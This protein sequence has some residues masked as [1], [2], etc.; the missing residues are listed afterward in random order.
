[1]GRLDY[2]PIVLAVG[3]NDPNLVVL[4]GDINHGI[5]QPFAAACPGRFYNVGILE[6]TIMSMAA[7]LARIGLLPVVHTI[8]P[9]LI[10]RSFEQIKHDFCYH[11]LHGNLITVG[12]A[13]D[14]AVLGCTHHY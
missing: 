9:F 12:S 7:G 6:P 5:L 13:F 2:C 10:E 8:A 14:Y 11:G 3:A 1:M 4:V